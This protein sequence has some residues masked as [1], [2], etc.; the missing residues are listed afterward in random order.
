MKKSLIL[1]LA[2]LGAATVSQATVC[3]T[4][5]GCAKKICELQKKVELTTEP[6]ALTRL[7]KALSEAKA[8]CTDGDLKAKAQ[9]KADE[10]TQKVERKIDE[11]KADA[12]KAKAKMDKA[13]A[14]GKE[15][16]AAKYRHKMEEKLQKAKRLESTH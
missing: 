15:D 4:L 1:T 16:K 5:Q 10:H 3:D 7:K 8:N 14:E 12:D 6:H 13:L 2:V 11:A 9:A